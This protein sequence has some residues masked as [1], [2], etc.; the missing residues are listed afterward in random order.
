MTTGHQ[1]TLNEDETE[2]TLT[3]Y[4]PSHT[5]NESEKVVMKYTIEKEMMNIYLL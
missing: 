1:Y 5:G 2:I 3:R 4:K